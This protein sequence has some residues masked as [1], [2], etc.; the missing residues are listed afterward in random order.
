MYNMVYS[1]GPQMKHYKGT[2]VKA[3]R[4]GNIL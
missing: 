4:E 1:D 2:A 3:N